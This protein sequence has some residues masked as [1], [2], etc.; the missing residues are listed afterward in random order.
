[1]LP[2][3][4][5][6]E[7]ETGHGVAYTNPDSSRKFFQWLVSYVDDN[8]ILVK[9]ENLGYENTAEKMIEVAKRCLGIWQRLVHVTGG[10]TGA[11]KKLLLLDDMEVRQ[12]GGSTQH[13]EG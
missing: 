1:M 12:G 3:E 6:Y 7:Y 9:L 4:K 13:Y 10:G 5:A 2:L 11:D 8:T